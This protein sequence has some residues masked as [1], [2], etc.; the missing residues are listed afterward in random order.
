M[1]NIMDIKK[2]I[3]KA[4]LLAKERKVAGGVIGEV[5]SVLITKKG[6]VFWGCSNYPA[7]NFASWRKPNLPQSKDS[8]T[9]V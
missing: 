8:K 1:K 6:K 5:G 2:M 7:C 9:D 4:K 3:A